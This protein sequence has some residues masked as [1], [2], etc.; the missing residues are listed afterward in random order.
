M[1]KGNDT[2][3]DTIESAHEFVKLLDAVLAETRTEISAD[4]T[5]ESAVT[6]NRRLDALRV[7]E[8]HLDRLEYHLKR[9]SRLLNDLRT[10]RRRLFEERS[11]KSP[12]P[13]GTQPPTHSKA[14][15]KNGQPVAAA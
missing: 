1:R 15:P 11:R 12:L 8:Y 13:A 10:V 14:T 7:A 9:S 4:I 5:R 3:F 6:P 2:P